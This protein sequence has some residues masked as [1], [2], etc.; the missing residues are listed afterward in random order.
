MLAQPNPPFIK[1]ILFAEFMSIEADTTT[2]N[3]GR[4]AFE[5]V[6][7][8]PPEDNMN[9]NDLYKEE[10]NDDFI[11]IAIKGKNKDGRTLA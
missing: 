10:Y 4:Q 6:H 2:Y 3:D 5:V 7:D 1:T 9:V 8:V 11:A